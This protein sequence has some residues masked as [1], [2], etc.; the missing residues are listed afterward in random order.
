MLPMN[1]L[2][3][4]GQTADYILTGTWGSKAFQEAKREGHGP[5]GLGRQGR[6]LFA[7][8]GRRR[9]EVQPDAAYV[10]ITS[11][12]T[13]QGV[14]FPIEPDTGSM[15]LVCDAVDAIFSRGRWPSIAMG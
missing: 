7:S 3:G 13:I 9:V 2:R 10:H 12:E 14:E 11:N 15:P 8:A 4:T 5:R 1:L 6:Q